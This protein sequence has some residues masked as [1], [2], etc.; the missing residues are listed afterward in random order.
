MNLRSAILSAAALSVS[1]SAGPTNDFAHYPAKVFKGP[2]V[3]PEDDWP[4]KDESLSHGISF[5]GHFTLVGIPCGT[6]CGSFRLVDRRTGKM[7][8]IP[9]GPKGLDYE[10]VDTRATSNLL[11][12][13]WVSAKF[14]GS[15]DIFPPCYRQNFVWTGARF[16]PLARPIKAKCPPDVSGR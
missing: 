10:A 16:R 9:E 14:D 11:K 2:L 5:G 3:V 6:A 12:V 7:F 1:A 15:G 13:L 4:N 8:R